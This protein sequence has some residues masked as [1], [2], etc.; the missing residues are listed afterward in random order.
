MSE[1]KKL[2]L[3]QMDEG[4]KKALFNSDELLSDAKTLLENGRWARAFLLS[5]LSM[6][7]LGK[8]ILLVGLSSITNYERID[9]KKFWEM[10]K[11]RKIDGND[12]HLL[13]FFFAELKSLENL[14]KNLKGLQNEDKNILTSLGDLSLFSDFEKNGFHSP[15]EVITNEIAS[16]WVR[17][18]DRYLN[19]VNNFDKNIIGLDGLKKLRKSEIIIPFEPI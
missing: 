2:S 4:R 5:L 7:E 13:G 16:Y 17:V 6:E 3:E 15:E 12:I 9:W 18:A 8:Y 1:I 19:S 14:E 11:F 10:Y